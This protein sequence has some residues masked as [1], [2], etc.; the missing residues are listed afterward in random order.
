MRTTRGGAW[1]FAKKAYW[2][3]LCAA[4]LFGYWLIVST[5]F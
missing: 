2:I 4:A 3:L 5:L 1:K